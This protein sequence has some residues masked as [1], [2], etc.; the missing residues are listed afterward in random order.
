MRKWTYRLWLSAPFWVGFALDSAQPVRR[1]TY[2]VVLTGSTNPGV[3][4]A[5]SGGPRSPGERSRQ[6]RS[7]GRRRSDLDELDQPG[8]ISTGSITRGPRSPGALDH[9]RLLDH[10]GPSI[11]RVRRSP[12]RVKSRAIWPHRAA[13]ARIL[14]PGGSP[15]WRDGRGGF[16]HER[17]G[18]RAGR[19]L[20]DL[21][22]KPHRGRRAARP[23][24]R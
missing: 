24:E 18:H 21:V 14:R 16:S 5:S 1:V 22:P 19:K 2:G 10:P 17:T 3:E 4:T 20:S 12:G 8:V 15:P 9:P 6:V 11:T 23:R 7:T 13:A